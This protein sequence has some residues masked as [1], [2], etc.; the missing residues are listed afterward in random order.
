MA[1]SDKELERLLNEKNK[2]KGEWLTYEVCNYY[3]EKAKKY[4]KVNS[5]DAGLKRELRLEL[6]NRYGL[7]DIEAINILNGFYIS[8]FY[9]SV[10]CTDN[11]FVVFLINYFFVF[12]RTFIITDRF[13]AIQCKRFGSW[14]L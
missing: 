5:Q 2:H 6:Q 11:W 7:L 1:A 9:Y 3:R 8:N 12:F 13:N 4:N 10:N 14:K